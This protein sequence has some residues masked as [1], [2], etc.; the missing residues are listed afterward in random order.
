MVAGRDKNRHTG[1]AQ[2]ADQFIPC[3]VICIVAVQQ[4]TAEQKNIRFFALGKLRQTAQQPPLL[5]A[6]DR[7]LPGGEPLKRRI[8]MQIRRV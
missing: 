1:S 6:A 3:L 5:A 7:G 8:Q 4:V 2:T